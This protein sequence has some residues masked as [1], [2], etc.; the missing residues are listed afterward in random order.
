M[1]FCQMGH[2]WLQVLV[3]VFFFIYTQMPLVLFCSFQM[4]IISVFYFIQNS[5]ILILSSCDP[6][7]TKCVQTFILAKQ[8]FG[9]ISI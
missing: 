9:I 8:S 3:S 2:I 5:I 6:S 1:I 4:V 7:F